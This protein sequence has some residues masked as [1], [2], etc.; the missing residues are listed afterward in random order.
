MSVYSEYKIMPS[1]QR[2]QLRVASAAKIICDSISSSLDREGIITVCLFHDM[3]NI[4]K[5]DLGYFLDFLEPEGLEYW[6]K[7]KDEYVNK[8]GPDEKIATDSICREIGLSD[9]W[10]DHLNFVGFS[11]I[12]QVFLSDSLE[13]K[14]CCYAD[15]RVGPYGVLS[16][17]ERLAEG[18]KRYE[19]KKELYAAE[20][21]EEAARTLKNIESQ[22]FSRASIKPEF[23]SD[24]SIQSLISAL[25]EKEI[26]EI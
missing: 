25:S 1:L 6:Q 4:I 24:E 18:R 5:S 3:G 20:E 9:V 21:F 23:V 13:K 19:G 14:I 16:I 12:K 17:D 7:V 10:M 2:H 8:Y 11:K 26:G 22:I 15:Q